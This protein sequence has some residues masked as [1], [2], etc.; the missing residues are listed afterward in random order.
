ME[1]VFESRGVVRG[2]WWNGWFD[3]G[4][5]EGLSS[6]FGA[7]YADGGYVYGGLEV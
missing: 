4:S 3:D 6:V 2:R 1:Y 5:K 7:F